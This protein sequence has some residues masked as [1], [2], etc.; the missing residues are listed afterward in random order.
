MHASDGGFIYWFL[1]GGA[2]ARFVLHP[3]QDN[4]VWPWDVFDEY[5]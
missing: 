5:P 3:L 2:A 4:L 1:G